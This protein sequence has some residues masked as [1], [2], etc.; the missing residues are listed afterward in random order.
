MVGGYFEA[1]STRS[2][3]TSKA[4]LKGASIEEIMKVCFRSFITGKWLKPI[5][6]NL[7][8]LRALKRGS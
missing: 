4:F 8:S 5:P 3:S 7:L 1:H 6:V 2:V